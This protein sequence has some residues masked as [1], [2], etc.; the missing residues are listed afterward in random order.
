M[1]IFIIILHFGDQE[2]TLDCVRSIIK[3]KLNFDRLIIVDNNQNFDSKVFKDK[4][5]ILRNK[6]NL[7]F[8]GGVNVGIRHALAKG[9]DYILLLNNDTIIKYNFLRELTKFFKKNKTAGILSPAI[10]YEKNHSTVYDTGGKINKIFGR[11]SHEEVTEVINKSPKA[12]D[13][14]SGCCMLIKKEVFDKV[15][16]F[17]AR[18]FLYYEDVDFCI[19]AKSKGFLTYVLPEVSIEH[20]LSKGVGRGSAV[21]AYNQ[22]KSALQFGRKH[23]KRLLLLNRLFILVQSIYILVKNPVVGFHAFLAFKYL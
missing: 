13:Y 15:G 14:V 17:D 6:K 8:A 12:V 2:V 21:A 1:K 16:L 9:A 22:T 23:F 19:R 20:A 3:A 4:I 18:F 11:T 7:G 10:K 5:E